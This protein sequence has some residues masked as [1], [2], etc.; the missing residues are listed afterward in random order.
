MD[1]VAATE[2]RN[3]CRRSELGEWMGLRSEDGI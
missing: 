2:A 1:E 3:D